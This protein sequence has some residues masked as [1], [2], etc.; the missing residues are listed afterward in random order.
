MAQGHQKDYQKNV[1]M[2]IKHQALA[3]RHQAHPKAEM[4][5]QSHNHQQDQ[6]QKTTVVVVV[7]IMVMVINNLKQDQ[8]FDYVISQHRF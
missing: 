8:Q 5:K 1:L 3:D 2:L 6:P 4:V 7:V